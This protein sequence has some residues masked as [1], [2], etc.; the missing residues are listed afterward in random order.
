MY[1][2]AGLVSSLALALCSSE[3]VLCKSKMGIRY[4]QEI[5]DCR[6]PLRS[7]K[8]DPLLCHL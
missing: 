1:G 8:Q 4:M 2:L 3:S 5:D 6:L 7:V